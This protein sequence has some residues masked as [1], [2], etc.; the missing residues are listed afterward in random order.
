MKKLLVVI[1]TCA[2]FAGDAYPQETADA[3]KTIQPTIMVI[4]FAQKGQS[5]RSVYERDELVRIAITKV[6]E[7]FDAR[8][9]NT[10]DLRAKL[11]QLSNNEVIQED[12]ATDM[13]DEII[14]L[15]GADVYVEV[16]ANKNLSGSGNSV[17]VIMTAYDAF[18][19]ESYSN[20][21]ANSPKFYTDNFE[22]L[23]SSAVEDEIDNFLN[24]INEKF[25]DIIENGRT[26]VLNIGFLD[27]ADN[28]FDME[29]GDEG[30]FLSDV[31]EDWVYDNA[32]KNYYHIQGTTSNKMI[33]DIIK[34]PLKDDRGRN[35][36]ISRFAAEFRNYLKDFGLESE[37]VINGNNVNIT[38]L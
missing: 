38:I 33:F 5:L 24:Q 18:S 13:K 36:R 22:K 12:Q 4:P 35:F 26:L 20:K 2:L 31:V 21:V 8:G 1:L 14:K 10:I 27:G 9:V 6:K 11:K 32:Y 17:T 7:G 16:E 28:D 23:V 30:D 19:G 29:V 34:V 37:R 25:T 15:S 3:E